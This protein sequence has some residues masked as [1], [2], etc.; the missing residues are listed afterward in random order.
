MALTHRMCR[1]PN[2][3]E[4]KAL[5][6]TLF[7]YRGL[8]IRSLKDEIKEDSEYK[9]TLLLTGILCLLHVDVSL[10]RDTKQQHGAYFL[11]HF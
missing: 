2:H 7:K 3:L 9:Q 4:F 8:A 11:S 10:Y 1:S 6:V 5:Q